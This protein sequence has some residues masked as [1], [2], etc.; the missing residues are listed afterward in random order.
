MQFG[1]FFWA[2]LMAAPDDA[3]DAVP[4]IYAGPGNPARKIMRISFRT[5]TGSRMS[6]N[7]HTELK[8]FSIEGRSQ[9]A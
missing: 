4:A 2:D 6:L 8:T 7:V 9:D 1:K 3:Q 5:N